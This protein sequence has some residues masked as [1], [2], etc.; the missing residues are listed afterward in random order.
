METIHLYNINYSEE[1]IK[2]TSKFKWKKE[3][4]EKI[5]KYALEQMNQQGRNKTKASKLVPYE[6][7]TDRIISILIQRSPDRYLK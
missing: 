3:V 1:E 4:K 6:K 2:K 5:T 7:L